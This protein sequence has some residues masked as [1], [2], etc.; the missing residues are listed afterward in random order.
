MDNTIKAL[1]VDPSHNWKLDNA[2]LDPD[3]KAKIEDY[4]QSFKFTPIP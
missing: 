1:A 4:I 2:M 3:E